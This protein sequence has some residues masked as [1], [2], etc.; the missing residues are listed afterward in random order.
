MGDPYVEPAKDVEGYIAHEKRQR[1]R[2][3]V[4]FLVLL[5]TVL[6][7][8][9]TPGVCVIVADIV[10]TGEGEQEESRRGRRR[11]RL[12][13]PHTRALSWRNIGPASYLFLSVFST[14]PAS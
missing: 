1:S 9:T 13:Y 11:G 4:L 5:G 7:A 2:R 6:N 3:G 12:A 8:F 14:E 10:A